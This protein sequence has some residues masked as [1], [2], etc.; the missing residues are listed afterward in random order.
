MSL[1]HIITMLGVFGVLETVL[2]PLFCND[3][4]KRL[5]TSYPG[6][7]LVCVSTLLAL[8]VTLTGTFILLLRK[9]RKKPDPVVE[10][11][12][13]KSRRNGFF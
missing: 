1:A 11:V 9:L 12:R 10:F 13:M 7:L 8:L 3:A 5:A 4:G 2:V 6:F